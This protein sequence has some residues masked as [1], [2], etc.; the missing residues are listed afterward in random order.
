MFSAFQSNSTRN[1]HLKVF[2]VQTYNVLYKLMICQVLYYPVLS[3]QETI[4]DIDSNG[5]G[6]LS[7]EEYIG[8]L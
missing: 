7:L 8:E 3:F 6:V 5:D 4:E 1:E 2:Y